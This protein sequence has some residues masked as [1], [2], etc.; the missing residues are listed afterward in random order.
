[1]DQVLPNGNNDMLGSKDNDEDTFDVDVEALDNEVNGN[2]VKV[3]ILSN[4]NEFGAVVE[5]PDNVN[6]NL[7]QDEEGWSNNVTAEYGQT[8]GNSE[9]ESPHSESPTTKDKIMKI[10]AE[11]RQEMGYPVDD[12]LHT[13]Q[14]NENGTAVTEHDKS[15]Q[16]D[17]CING[18]FIEPAGVAKVNFTE[19]ANDATSLNEPTNIRRLYLTKTTDVEL[20]TPTEEV[21]VGPLNLTCQDEVLDFKPVI[22]NSAAL[23]NE[24]SMNL[25]CQDES[26]EKNLPYKVV[27]KYIVIKSGDETDKTVKMHADLMEACSTLSNDKFTFIKNSNILHFVQ[28]HDNNIPHIKLA[29]SVTHDF[30]VNVTVN[31]KLLSSDHDLWLHVPNVCLNVEQVEHLL[32]TLATYE[33]CIGNPDE[34]LQNVMQYLERSEEES[35]QSE[36][37]YKGYRDE[38]NGSTIRSQDC[39]LLT[40]SKSGRCKNCQNY[41]RSLKK[42][43]QRKNAKSEPSAT[44]WLKSKKG[45]YLLS[46]SEK[47]EKLKQLREN[48]KQ[49]ESIIAGLERKNRDLLIKIS[50]KQSGE[51]QSYNKRN[52]STT[53]ENTFVYKVFTTKFGL[54]ST[55]SKET[56]N[57]LVS[58]LPAPQP[59]DIPAI[60]SP[61]SSNVCDV[62]VKTEPTDNMNETGPTGNVNVKVNTEQTSNTN[63][64][65][66]VFKTASGVSKPVIIKIVDD[67]NKI[68]D[69]ETSSINIIGMKDTSKSKSDSNVDEANKEIHPVFKNSININKLEHLESSVG[70]KEVESKPEKQQNKQGQVCK[71]CGK[72]VKIMRFHMIIHRPERFKCSICEKSFCRKSQLESHASIHTGV[73]SHKC[74]ICGQLFRCLSNLKRHIRIHTGDRPYT[75]DHCPKSFYTN[76]SRREHEQAVHLGTKPFGCTICSK[77]F[78]TR[79]SMHYHNRRQHKEA[80]VSGSSDH[81]NPVAEQ[82]ICEECGKICKSK[83]SLFS[84]K[85]THKKEI[86]CD[87]CEMKFWCQSLLKDHKQKKHLGNERVRN[88]ICHIC[89]MG[90]YDQPTLDQHQQVH[91]DA[92]PYKCSQCPASF[93]RPRHLRIHENAHNGVKPYQCTTCLKSF[94]TKYD[95]ETHELSVHQGKFDFVCP[96]CSKSFTRNKMLKSHMKTHGGDQYYK[97]TQCNK[98]FIRLSAL[99]KHKLTHGD[100]GLGTERL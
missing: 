74:P 66:G 11:Y 69:R 72:V 22:V 19:L 18:Q 47:N 3:E 7:H 36:Q 77:T 62:T 29:V 21:S 58:H 24:E 55:E 88:F 87:M 45:N 92:R 5:F 73:K 15:G 30:I 46:E 14:D 59:V 85:Y 50:E 1:M 96:I 65:I 49:Q 35:E 48:I 89:G 54:E 31:G 57:N 71:I 8:S 84:H 93:K 91:S 38:Y 37:K 86:S 10:L 63:D 13:S 56:N 9:N 17:R 2:R 33:V 52:K 95:M 94:S 64:I 41:R 44:N 79:Y 81:G 43:L 39:P 26:P 83:R 100:G 68:S 75:C 20:H 34:E 82:H 23:Y 16:G 27:N 67:K 70:L 12:N 60:P 80:A 51:K 4:V 28:L 40:N 6:E 78:K 61:T 76:Y 90:F 53:T 32:K 99:E 98:N 25:I 42:A 97:C